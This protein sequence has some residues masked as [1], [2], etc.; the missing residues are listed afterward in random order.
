MLYPIELWVPTLGGVHGFRGRHTRYLDAA[1]PG[2]KPVVPRWAPATSAS[3]WGGFEKAF[4]D[5]GAPKWG[6]RSRARDR[7]EGAKARVALYNARPKKLH[8]PVQHL[9]PRPRFGTSPNAPSS[10]ASSLPP[11]TPQVTSYLAFPKLPE[12]ACRSI[13][14]SGTRRRAMPRALPRL[15][16]RSTSRFLRAP[17]A[18][19]PPVA[20]A[21]PAR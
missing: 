1:G 11:P 18:V 21:R 19:V 14:F 4:S 16:A 2:V 5:W 6:W 3:G 7:G 17:T 8:P 15:R 10:F 20:P 12:P 9:R 13:A